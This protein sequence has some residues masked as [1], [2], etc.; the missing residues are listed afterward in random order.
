MYVAQLH[1]SFGAFGFTWGYSFEMEEL[2]AKHKNP[3]KTEIWVKIC[4]TRGKKNPK[5][6]GNKELV[7][8]STLRNCCACLP[9]K[10]VLEKS[11]ILD[12]AVTNT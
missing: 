3:R 4:E 1:N 8:A 9:S 6:Q 5:T 10:L 2:S 11:L 12:E 7:N